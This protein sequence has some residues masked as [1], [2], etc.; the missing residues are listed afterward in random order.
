MHRIAIIHLSHS[1]CERQSAARKLAA[2]ISLC[3]WVLACIPWPSKT[4]VMRGHGIYSLGITHLPITTPDIYIASVFIDDSNESYTNRR[5]CS[6][7]SLWGWFL[8]KIF[9]VAKD[10]YNQGR[11]EN[12]WRPYARKFLAPPNFCTC[13]L[14]NMFCLYEVQ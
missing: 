3:A 10:A 4:F 14:F 2:F 13:F 6:I 11:H 9:H 12:G 8:Q 5:T 1:S 7:S